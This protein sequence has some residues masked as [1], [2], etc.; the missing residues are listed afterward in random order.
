MMESTLPHCSPDAV[1]TPRMSSLQSGAVAGSSCTNM[2]G[3]SIHLASFAPT[4]EYSVQNT[5]SS[6]DVLVSKDDIE[7]DFDWDSIL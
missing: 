6:S 5:A 2:Q 3:K 7:Q 4:I 1:V